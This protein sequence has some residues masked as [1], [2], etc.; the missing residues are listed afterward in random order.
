MAFRPALDTTLLPKMSC[1][2]QLSHHHG[3]PLEIMIAL[4]DLAEGHRLQLAWMMD[5]L[6]GMKSEKDWVLMM[7]FLAKRSRAK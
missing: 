4:E 3:H 2:F 6:T 1:T 7:M 5:S